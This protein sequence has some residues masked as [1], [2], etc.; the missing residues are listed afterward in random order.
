MN[1]AGAVRG[2]D[3]VHGRET[4]SAKP[5]QCLGIAVTPRAYLHRSQRPGRGSRPG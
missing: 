2:A 4:V 1:A 3:V 5:V